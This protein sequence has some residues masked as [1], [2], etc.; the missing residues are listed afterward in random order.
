M[1]KLLGYVTYVVFFYGRY[2]QEKYLDTIRKDPSYTSIPAWTSPTTLSLPTDVDSRAVAFVVLSIAFLMILGIPST[3]MGFTWDQA[4]SKN[5]LEPYATTTAPPWVLLVSETIYYIAP[6]LAAPLL[7][8]VATWAYV[9]WDGAF[10][11]R[12]MVSLGCALVFAIASMQINSFLVINFTTPVGRTIGRVLFFPMMVLPFFIQRVFWAKEM[13]STV[14][15]QGLEELSMAWYV[16]G[17][18]LA[19]VVGLLALLVSSYRM[20]RY[21]KGFL[22]VK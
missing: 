2:E 19:A 10:F 11:Q 15:G 18:V 3:L 6:L 17:A 5:I 14:Q 22:N 1:E 20:G 13:T 9:G 8:F 16:G 4:R 21:R 12:S 7:A